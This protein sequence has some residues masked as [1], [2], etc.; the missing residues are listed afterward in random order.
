VPAPPAPAA[1]LSPSS[2][3]GAFLTPGTPAPKPATGKTL[4]APAVVKPK[5]KAQ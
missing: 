4:R 2:L 5:A 3:G 1:T